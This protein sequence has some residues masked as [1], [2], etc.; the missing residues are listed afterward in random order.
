MKL[1][2]HN[3][4]CH[5]IFNQIYKGWNYCVHCLVKQ[6]LLHKVIDI[7]T[8]LGSFCSSFFNN[9]GKRCMQEVA[10]QQL[11]TLQSDG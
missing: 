7:S 2:S 10:V 1:L 4:P 8:A 5:I 6:D 9:K 3:F 11:I